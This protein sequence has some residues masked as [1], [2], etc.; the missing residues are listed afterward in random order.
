MKTPNK[1]RPRGNEIVITA[2]FV[3]APKEK[4][5]IIN[6]EEQMVYFD[7][8]QTVLRVGSVVRDVY[9]GDVVCVNPKRFAKYQEQKSK[10][11]AA[12]EG[13]EKVLV[14]YEFPII[15]TAFGNVMLISDTDV[16]YIVEDGFNEPEPKDMTMTDGDA[17]GDYEEERCNTFSPHLASTEE[18]KKD[19]PNET[20]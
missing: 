13:Y 20:V 18:L 15:E 16:R 3:E 11:R 5:K 17:P 6:K 19:F 14:G 10:V 7:E 1:I 2:N 9:M 4:N 12:V 8:F